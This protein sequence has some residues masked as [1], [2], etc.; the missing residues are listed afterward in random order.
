MKNE[1]SHYFH[2]SKCLKEKPYGKSPRE[3]FKVEIG[4]TE[5]GL[6]VW[7]NRHNCNVINIKF[8]EKFKPLELDIDES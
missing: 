5:K 6:Q 8:K 1:I 4:W 2:C 3:W 7:C